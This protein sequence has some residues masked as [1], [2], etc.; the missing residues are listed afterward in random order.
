VLMMAF[1][2]FLFAIN[3]SLPYFSWLLRES[4]RMAISA[5]AT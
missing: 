2:C 3:R 4:K 5:D 1:I